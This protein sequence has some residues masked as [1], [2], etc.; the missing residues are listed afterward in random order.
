MNELLVLRMPGFAESAEQKARIKRLFS[1]VADP[2]PAADRLTT[3][4]LNPVN[5]FFTEI[6]NSWIGSDHIFLEPMTCPPNEY[7]SLFYSQPKKRI[8]Q[9]KRHYA[10]DLLLVKHDD[11]VI[12]AFILRG[13]F[14]MSVTA[15]KIEICYDVIIAKNYN[16]QQIAKIRAALS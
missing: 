11:E 2:L 4:I 3:L 14:I 5:P 1:S 6:A 16:E 10:L 13:I 7:W 15:N 9:P 12:R 8:V